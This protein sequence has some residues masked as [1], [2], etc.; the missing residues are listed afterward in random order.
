MKVNFRQGIARYQTDLNGNPTF[1]QR[2]GAFIDLVVSPDPTVLLFAHRN[3][4]YLIEELKSVHN[5]WGPFSGNTTQYLYWDVNLLTAQVTRGFTQ[6]PPLY[7]SVSPVNP[8]TDQHWFDTVDNVMRVWSGNKWIEKVRLFACTY[9]SSAIIIPFPKGSQAG[10]IGDYEAGHILLDTLGMPLRQSDGRFVTAADKLNV[11]NYGTTTVRVEA[12]LLSGM[13]NEYIPAFSGVQLRRG[14]RLELARSTDHTTRV[15]GIVVEDMYEGEVQNVVTR[16]IVK[17]GNW[18]WP[19]SVI[20]RPIFIDG[21]G[22]IT[23]T[24]PTSGVVQQLGFV[25]DVDSIVLEIKQPVVLDDTGSVITPPPPPPVGAP[26]ANFAAVTPTVGTVPLSVTFMDSSSGSP[27]LIEWDFGNDGYIDT[28]TVNPTFVFATPGIYTVRMRAS[29]AYGA[30]EKIITNMITA[31]A[32]VAGPTQTNLGISFNAPIQVTGGVQF[33][34]DVTTTNDG[35]LT[36]SN[37]KRKIKLRASDGSLPI[38]MSTPPGS[39]VS[40]SGI[41]MFVELPVLSTMVAGAV[42]VSTIGAIVSPTATKLTLEGSISSPE[43]DAE[44]RD[45]STNLSIGVRP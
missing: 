2:S 37:V 41:N 8:M 9:S 45:N 43:I 34:I 33:S 5:A 25:W 23:T 20:N 19:D 38:I 36:A 10:L 11:V 32:P 27:D 26:T 21:T 15:A 6:H 17:N 35:V 12:D 18:A 7:T 30:T 31:H 44:D 22:A 3:G 29:N 24:A 16:G 40:Q 1:L 13:A 14:G 42:Q 4:T 39:V 28:T